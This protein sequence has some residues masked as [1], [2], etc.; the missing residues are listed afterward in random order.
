MMDVLSEPQLAALA[1]LGGGILLGLAARLGRFCTM[2]AIEDALYGGSGLRLRMWGLAISVS[3]VLSFGLAGL[4]GFEPESTIYLEQAWTPLAS[5]LGGLMFGY[6][7]ALA[8]NCGYGALAR[9]GGGDMKAFVV[10]LVMGIAAYMTVSGPIAEIRVRVF[11]VSIA[12]EPVPG[13][14]HLGAWASGISPL[15]IGLALGVL[16][17]VASIGNSDLRRDPKALM[18][19]VAVAVAVV[20]GWAAT[21]WIAQTG[22]D[23]LPVTSH[24]Y[25]APIGESLLYLMTSSGSSVDFGI[26][27][28]AGVV[29][30]AFGGSVL[31]GHFRWEACEDARELRRLMLGAFL[32]GV[33]AVT[34]LGCSVGQGLSA[35]SVLALSAPV[36]FAA[37]FAGAALGLRHLILG[38]ASGHR[39]L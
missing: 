18:W 24:T 11:P 28:V 12:A 8:G 34:A 13:I 32:M 31:K 7:M 20:S 10:V 2:G 30:G 23:G 26:G 27:S 25:S 19:S 36:T 1:G 29:V 38:A 33:G 21:S 37:I 9:V 17:V 35:F 4:G 16:G 39:A 6:G 15:A 22:F 3:V 14:A 5:I